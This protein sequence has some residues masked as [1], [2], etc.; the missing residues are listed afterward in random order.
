[1]DVKCE[2]KPYLRLLQAV[3][4]N[5]FFADPTTDEEI[6]ELVAEVASIDAA[7]ELTAVTPCKKKAGGIHTSP[8]LTLC[9]PVSLSR[10]RCL[11]AHLRV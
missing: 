9:R 2:K 3:V 7:G 11:A 10:Q 8:Y 6:S 5:T 4:R 1:M